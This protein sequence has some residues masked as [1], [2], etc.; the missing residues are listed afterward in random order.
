MQQVWKVLPSGNLLDVSIQCILGGCQLLLLLPKQLP[1]LLEM[2]VFV[3]VV[4]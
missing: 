2:F 3:V 4:K 1:H